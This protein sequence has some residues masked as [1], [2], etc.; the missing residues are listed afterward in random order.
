M[1]GHCIMKEQF[2]RAGCHR[3][4][5]HSDRSHHWRTAVLPACPVIEGTMQTDFNA[6]T[7]SFAETRRGI[8]LSAF[9]G[10][11]L[12]LCV[13]ALLWQISQNNLPLC[14]PNP[15]LSLGWNSPVETN[16]QCRWQP[17]TMKT[18]LNRFQARLFCAVALGIGSPL[19]SATAAGWEVGTM[20]RA[21]SESQRVEPGP[22]SAR[23]DAPR[24]NAPH[25]P[26]AHICVPTSWTGAGFQ[27]NGK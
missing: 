25:V 21:T 10:L 8:E 14:T 27:D 20:E 16:S 3:R 19:T 4:T 2:S 11:S 9:L 24:P 6:E 18:K 12:R 7:Q 1:K 13:K 15:A 17:N 5:E 22:D 26:C 23:S